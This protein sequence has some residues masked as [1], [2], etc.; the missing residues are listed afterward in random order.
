M[1]IFRVVG[2]WPSFDIDVFVV[3]MPLG[4]VDGGFQGMRHIRNRK[5]E[6]RAQTLTYYFVA[7][8]GGCLSLRNV[9]ICI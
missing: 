8:G 9:G 4:D 1:S 2:L 5:G 6:E 7:E 3:R